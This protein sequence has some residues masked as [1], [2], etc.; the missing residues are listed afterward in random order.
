[1]VTFRRSSDW[2]RDSTADFRRLW[3]ALLAIDLMYKL[4]AVAIITP[5]AGLVVHI[6]VTSSGDAAIADQDILY[7]ILS[8]IGVAGL[9]AV[10]TVTLAAVALEQA[11]LMTVGLA[12]IHDREP[13]PISALLF[14]LRRALPV[15]SAVARIVVRVLLIAIPFLAAAGLVYDVLLTKFDIN[16]YL[17]ERPREFW[18]AA[19]LGAVLAVGLAVVLVPRLIAWSFTLPLLLFEHV[20]PARALQTSFDRTRGDRAD[21][22]LSY[23]TWFAVTSLLSG[24]LLG[25]I[26]LAGR[27]LIPTVSHSLGLFVPLIGVFFV[28]WLA[29]NVFVSFLQSA[30]FALLTVR[31]YT[32]AAG[33]TPVWPDL[34]SSDLRLRETVGRRLTVRKL[35]AACLALA[36]AAVIVGVVLLERLP[37]QDD[38]IV[39][40]HRG[41]AAAAPENT[42][43]AFDRAIADGTDY[44][45]LDVQETADGEVVIMH[46]SDFMKVAGL[47]LKIWDAT[48][49]QIRAIDMGSWYDSAFS[50]ERVPTLHEVLDRCKDRTKVCIE[51]K[52]YGHDQR[53]EER[54]VEI[55]EA[56]GMVNQVVLM[57]L[58]YEGVKKLNALRPDW[59]VGLLAAKAVGDITELDADF[60][61][62]NSGMGTRR[63]VRRAHRSGKDVYLWTV[64]DAAQMSRYL[65][66]GVDGIITDD[67]AKARG[68]LEG[69][70]GMNIAQRLALALAAW[71]GKAPEPAHDSDRI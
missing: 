18:I 16:Y 50:G 51:L 24:A 25:L 62:V 37:L 17:Q 46:D 20:P 26:T 13:A 59:T 63:F 28:A 55:V 49:E 64:N 29:A 41:A 39:I 71:A 2:I 61:A 15:T 4:V 9:I 42:V 54:V 12:A 56:A 3:P 66:M 60:L 1:M 23:V 67:P 43:A 58:N 8:P 11:C 48:Y 40:A 32:A 31:T 27:A 44:I 69:R 6:V 30:T 21:I 33:V 57:S 70:A 53:L 7:L 68:V 5:L 19:V 52:Y 34:E 45:E 36:A 65:S 10:T 22:A 38:A 14:S 35:L 47:D